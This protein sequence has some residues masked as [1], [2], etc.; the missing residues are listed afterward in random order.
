QV[1]DNLLVNAL[2]YVPSGGHVTVELTKPGNAPGSWRL[3]VQDDGPGLSP[4][5]LSHVFERFY[6][7]DQARSVEKAR[8]V[9]GSG[10]GL[11]IVRQIVERHG[12]TVRARA[13]TP[14]G[15]AIE[16]DLP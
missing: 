13:A 10:L 4:E 2:R 7:G 5:E 16:I 6:R 14:T 3:L 15:L 9:A 8:D 11:A 1:L 12:G